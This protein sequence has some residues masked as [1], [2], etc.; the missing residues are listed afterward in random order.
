MHPED[1]KASLRKRGVTLASIAGELG[2]SQSAISHLVAGRY[3]SARAMER[4]AGILGKPVASIWA[5][6]PVQRRKARTAP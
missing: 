3:R 1:I 6:K 2:V 4:I 5:S